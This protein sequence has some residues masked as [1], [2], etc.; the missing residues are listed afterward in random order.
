MLLDIMK[1]ELI[2]YISK[3]PEILKLFKNKNMLRNYVYKA[4]P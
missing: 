3:Q 4:L 1:E 2:E